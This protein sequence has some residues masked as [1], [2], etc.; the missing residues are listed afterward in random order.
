MSECQSD[1]L[2]SCLCFLTVGFQSYRVKKR[3]PAS[4]FAICM[5]VTGLLFL[6]QCQNQMQAGSDQEMLIMCFVFVF[7][8]CC[9]CSLRTGFSFGTENWIEISVDRCR[10][11]VYR[12]F[13]LF[14][15]ALETCLGVHT[16]QSPQSLPI[17]GDYLDEQISKSSLT[18]DSVAGN[19]C[20][21]R[22][23]HHLQRQKLNAGQTASWW[24]SMNLEFGKACC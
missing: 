22:T 10:Q 20:S 5:V 16:T 17:V 19:L 2:A 14:L 24:K 4:N 15:I 9:S 7:R 8:T 6:P 13:S 11:T 3:L 12:K 23:V 1:E 18:K 21:F